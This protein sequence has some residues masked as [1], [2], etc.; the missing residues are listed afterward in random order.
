MLMRHFGDICRPA[1]L[2]FNILN[3][4]GV[5]CAGGHTYNKKNRPNFH[6]VLGFLHLSLGR[7]RFQVPC[8]LNKAARGS[9]GQK[10]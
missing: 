3:P 4:I 5:T 10:S 2:H 9:F 7:V 1:K 6:L 8:M